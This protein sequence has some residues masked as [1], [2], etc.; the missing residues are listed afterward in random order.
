MP[1]TFFLLPFFVFAAL[2]FI[3]LSLRVMIV[4]SPEFSATLSSSNQVI[5]RRL[6]EQMFSPFRSRLTVLACAFSLVLLC[7]AAARAQADGSFGDTDADPV[8]LFE[9]GQDAHARGDLK[10]ALEFYEEA[11]KLR[12]EF[13]EAEYQRATAHVSLG[14]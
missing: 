8:K 1:L 9:R 4:S 14:Q 7:A 11:L 3:F 5:K 10:L 2:F 12:P 13:P 6:S